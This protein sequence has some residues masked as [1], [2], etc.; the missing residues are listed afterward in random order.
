ML[1]AA[2]TELTPREHYLFHTLH[3]GN[4]PFANV[5]AELDLAVNPSDPLFY[6]YFV[7]PDYE[8]YDGPLLVQLRKPTP[9]VIG[10]EPGSGKTMLR[11]VLE[12]LCRTTPDGTLVVSPPLKGGQTLNLESDALQRIISEAIATDMFIQVM[13]QYHLLSFT[14]EQTHSLADYWHASIPGF[15][16][17]LRLYLAEEGSSKEMSAWWWPA[18]QRAAV[19][20]TRDTPERRQFLERV[21]TNQDG[22]PL[23]S[24]PDK[25]IHLGLQLAYVLGFTQLFLLLDLNNMAEVNAVTQIIA[26]LHRANPILAIYPK[27]FVPATIYTRTTTRLQSTFLPSTIFS[28]I[29]TWSSPE[30]LVS[31]VASRWR[32]GRSWVRDFDTLA[33]QEI[34]GK[35]QSALVTAAYASPRRLLQLINSLIE[36]HANR[37]PDEPL[38]T[39]VDWQQ[40][41]R[42]WSYGDPPLAFSIG[43]PQGSTMPNG[44]VPNI[45]REYVSDLAVERSHDL[46][47]AE[48]WRRSSK[49]LLT[50]VGPPAIGKTWFLKSLEQRW[51]GRDKA[52]FW[53]DATEWLTDP[54]AGESKYDEQRARQS[55]AHLVDGIKGKCPLS[56]SG[57]NLAELGAVI[58]YLA[59][60]LAK[61]YSDSR[62]ILLIDGADEAESGSW[63]NIEREI[64]EPFAREASIR[65]VIALRN[66]WKFSI[67]SL[68]YAET[69]LALGNLHNPQGFEQLEKLWDDAGRPIPLADLTQQ[70]PAY[71]WSH[72]GLNTFV[73]EKWQA[74]NYMALGSDLLPDWLRAVGI[75]ENKLAVIR[76]L[77]HEIDQATTGQTGINPSWTAEEIAQRLNIT[78]SEAWDKIEELRAFWLVETEGNRHGILDGLRE[79][80]HGAF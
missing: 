13:D 43:E 55:F 49:R 30:K 24:E 10:G 35:L 47:M 66:D 19:R 52:V 63:R 73:F 17:K 36:A 70:L 15:G 77:L 75:P 11:Y 60:S 39:A 56:L 31:L 32:A 21:T 22:A 6:L 40:M 64:L 65:F 16:R 9:S 59:I 1:P 23:V 27:Y 41:C 18:W 5:S 29:I 54:H 72:P 71:T 57:A 12:Q 8:P 3:L 4:D 34:S 76:N 2:Q 61:C 62:I 80:V 58:E 78:V 50:V 68:R 25:C 37:A 48:G 28:G 45:R 14:P 51:G 74:A 33:S 26:N 38:I 42:T 46:D 69:R 53:L 7:E 20:F 79:L 67:T 44:F